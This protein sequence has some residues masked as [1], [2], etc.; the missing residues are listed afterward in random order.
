MFQVFTSAFDE[1][2]IECIKAWCTDDEVEAARWRKDGCQ[3]IR[4]DGTVDEWNHHGAENER[5]SI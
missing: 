5:E 2:G 3:V 1:S 4:C